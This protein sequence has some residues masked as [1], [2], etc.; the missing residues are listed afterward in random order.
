[1]VLLEDGDA[2]ARILADLAG[3]GFEFARK[4]LEEGRLAGAVRADDSVAVATLEG[5]VHFLE[6]DAATVLKTDIRD[7]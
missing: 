6:E 3:V 1:V 7:V 2:F 5:E 4:D